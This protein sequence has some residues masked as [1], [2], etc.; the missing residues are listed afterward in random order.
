MSMARV[1]IGAVVLIDPLP[2]NNLHS[3][4]S[5]LKIL[6]KYIDPILPILKKKIESS[7]KKK[8][9]LHAASSGNKSNLN[10]FERLKKKG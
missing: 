5:R 4:P 9:L 10:Y 3:S 6:Q 1:D 8:P 2:I 7:K